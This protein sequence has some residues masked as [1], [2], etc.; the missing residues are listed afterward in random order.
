[1]R[2]ATPNQRKV[3]PRD[4]TKSRGQPAINSHATGTRHNEVIKTPIGAI[5]PNVIQAIGIV[6][7][8][9]TKLAPSDKATHRAQPRGRQVQGARAQPGRQASIPGKRAKP[10]TSARSSHRDIAGINKMS[11]NVAAYE[12]CNETLASPR[13]PASNSIVN[14]APH[15]FKASGRRPS[16]PM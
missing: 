2:D 11:P 16:G 12:S 9:A 14:A 8:T 1:M 4:A 3:P 7:K 10:R 5:S 15:K 13:V 6:A